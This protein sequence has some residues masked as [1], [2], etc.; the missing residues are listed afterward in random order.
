[1]ALKPEIV[2]GPAATL[3][4]ALV[5]SFVTGGMLPNGIV[6]V[7]GVAST[8]PW[9]SVAVYVKVTLPLN[10]PDGSNLRLEAC[11]GVKAC[12]AVTAV[13]PSARYSTPCA[14][15]GSVLTV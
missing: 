6:K 8:A 11:A 13:T 12:P 7:A 3:M 10:V 9:L 14:A 5:T 15:G 4:A 1:M 2:V